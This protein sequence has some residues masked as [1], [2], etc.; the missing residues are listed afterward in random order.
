MPWVICGKTV[1][2]EQIETAKKNGIDRKKVYNRIK[3]SGR[4]VEDAILKEMP[5]KKRRPYTKSRKY[6]YTETDIEHAA[7]CGIKKETFI[8]RMST[9]YSKGEAMTA[10]IKTGKKGNK[11]WNLYG[12]KVTSDLIKKAQ[13]NGIS[14]RLVKER[15]KSGMSPET[16][17]TK[18]VRSYGVPK[19]ER[20]E[21]EKV[22]RRKK[23]SKYPEADYIA[24]AKKG[25]T[26]KVYN[27]R[28]AHGW[29]KTRAI[30]EP[31]KNT[32][33]PYNKK[34]IEEVMTATPTKRTPY[35]ASIMFG[36]RKMLLGY[37][38]TKEL[39]K[40]AEKNALEALNADV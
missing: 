10:I 14:Y 12:Q 7:A 38:P 31:L 24:A 35:K 4:S 36:K 27:Q 21:K 23:T 37:C 20:R 9:G 28:R 3:K 19:E 2:D 25:I 29:S 1:T 40:A 18:A 15:L 8:R 30:N 6:N 16:A 13:E 17:V 33:S 26:K 22:K 5:E 34:P 11:E 32:R 39:A